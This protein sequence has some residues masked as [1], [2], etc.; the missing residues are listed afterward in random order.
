SRIVERMIEEFERSGA[1]AVIAFEEVPRDQVVHY[2]IARPQGGD[3]DMFALADVVEKPGVAEAPRNLAVAPRY[4][5]RPA[6]FDCLAGTEPGKGGEIQLTDAIRQLI[7]RGGKVLG[8]RLPAGERRYD[9][10]TF[11]SY[12]QAFC[13]FALADPR[14]GPGLH[15]FVRKLLGQ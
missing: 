12:F 4:V 13:Q 14:Y 10:G 8:I 5:F 3:G 7:R 15:D 11:E 1:D 6:V 9:I 2:G